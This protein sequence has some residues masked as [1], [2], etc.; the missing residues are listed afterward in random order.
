MKMGT[1]SQSN[2]MAPAGEYFFEVLLCM[3]ADS[4]TIKFFQPD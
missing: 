1:Y 2:G 3:H 4:A